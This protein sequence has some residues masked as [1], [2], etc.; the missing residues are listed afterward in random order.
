RRERG[1]HA[2]A[3]LSGRHPL[4]PPAHSARSRAMDAVMLRAL[5]SGRVDGAD[6]FTRLFTHVPTERLLRFLDGHTRLRE[7]L[8]V[9]IRTPVLPM[10][11]SAAELPYLPRR[12][13]PGQ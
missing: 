9:G 2:N 13:F 11:R 4:P 3:L 12:P 10:L 7:D 5:D 6:F 1:G 8:T